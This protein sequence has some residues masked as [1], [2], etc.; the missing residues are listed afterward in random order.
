[1]HEAKLINDLIHQ[2]ETVR[3]SE[4]ANKVTAVKV[5]LGALSQFS[6]EHFREHFN[7]ASAGTAVEGADLIVD[8][9][10]DIHDPLAQEVIIE[11]ID[12]Q[13]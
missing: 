7:I 9:A 3:K 8:L 12:L 4:K 10:D 11:S 2:V 6:E 13:D 1:M 5:K